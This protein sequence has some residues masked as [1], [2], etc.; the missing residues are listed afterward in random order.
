MQKLWKTTPT[1]CCKYVTTDFGLAMILMS[2]KTSPI[3]M[4]PT[5]VFRGRDCFYLQKTIFWDTLIHTDGRNRMPILWFL[6]VL[7][8][9]WTHFVSYFDP[10]ALP[11]TLSWV[12]YGNFV[13][14]WWYL[15]TFQFLLLKKSNKFT[16][17]VEVE[18]F[19]LKILLCVGYPPLGED[20]FEKWVVD[21]EN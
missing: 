20:S 9:F 4:Y 21:E 6:D 14:W 10:F 13:P 1:M 16:Q 18:H 5:K 7:G 2:E 3:Q 12:G 11:L 15:V 8:C 19:F 17:K